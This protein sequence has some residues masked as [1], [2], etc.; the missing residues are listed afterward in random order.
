M[1]LNKEALI[2]Y[3][4]INRC[5]V[6]Y[7]VASKKRL[8]AA[9][10]DALDIHPLGERTIDKDI[11]DMRFDQRLG[12]NA[13]ISFDRIKGGYYYEDPD[14]TIDDIPINEDELKSL[15]FAATM[16]S[17]YKTIGIFSTF[18]GA[19][20]KIVDTIN[21]RRMVKEDSYYPFIAF[22]TA[23]QLKGSEYLE[24]IIKAIMEKKAISFHYQRFNIQK[25]YK[26]IIHPCLLKEYRNRWYLV[27]LN[28]DLQ[29]IRTYGLDRIV[30]N[31]KKPDEI[32]TY[33]DIK[34]QTTSFDP[35]EY[36]KATVGII[37]PQTKPQHIL[38]EFSPKQAN[39]IL[40]QPIHETQEVIENTDQH[41]VVSIDV[42]PTYE[43]ISMILG[44]G[45]D[46]KVLEPLSLKG[47]IIKSLKEG[48][49]QYD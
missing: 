37:S 7:G 14:Y 27:G 5:L 40:T 32:F 47:E 13:P 35:K 3:R 10:E 24:P 22:E 17:Q 26:H 39:Y 28:H 20:Q 44:W 31:P 2:R 15:S 1:P 6:D 12:F 49:K 36:F 16:L 29:E 34:F 19:V 25:A 43:L 45:N 42:C 38:L 8:T 4:V 18:S 23:P 11:S 30:P 48:L 21:I 46:V 41:L 9:C 33:P